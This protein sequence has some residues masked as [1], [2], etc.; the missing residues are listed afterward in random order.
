[1]AGTDRLTKF[2]LGENYSKAECHMR[3][4]FKAVTSN[5]EIIIIL[6]QTAQFHSNMVWSLRKS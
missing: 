4:M 3:H 1:M 6:P 5:T 2:K